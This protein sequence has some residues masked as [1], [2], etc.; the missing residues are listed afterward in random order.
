MQTF[1]IKH[2]LLV[3]MIGLSAVVMVGCLSARTESGTVPEFDGNRAYGIL[4]KQVDIGPR[5]PGASG[6]A[7][8]AEYIQSQLAPYADSVKVQEFSRTIRGKDLGMQN[9]IAHF[10]KGARKWVL[11]AAH[12]DTR[13]IADMEVNP[14]KKKTAIPGA[15]DGG[16][17]VA[18]LLELAKIFAKQKPDVG[19]VMVFFDGEDYGPG[20][21][22]MFLGAK[23]FAAKLPGSAALDGKPIAIKYGILLDMV[24]DKNLGIYR[25]QNSAE[26]APEIVDK[27]WT[28]ASKLGY[29]DKFLDG[30]LDIMDDHLS[31]IRAGLKCIDIIDFDY[32]P[33]H[34]L[35]DTPD[36]CSAD[37]LKTVGDVVAHVVYEEKPE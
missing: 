34:T 22:N 23:E 35:D 31:L 3:G 24:G 27:V 7:V 33:W 5:Y 26:A 15:N 13:P 19:V 16:S 32:G 11:L 18:V 37:S 21:D 1:K 30:E 28:T 6:H 10:N 2:A 12:W 17:G 29:K 36:K 8:T 25:E 20:V 14:V 9:I 4:K